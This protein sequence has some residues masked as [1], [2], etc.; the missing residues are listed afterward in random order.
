MV[1]S[2]NVQITVTDALCLFSTSRNVTQRVVSILHLSGRLGLVQFG[3][4]REWFLGLGLGL[5]LGHSRVL[6]RCENGLDPEDY[7]IGPPPKVHL[8]VSIPC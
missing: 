5:G 7:R 8:S 4:S 3:T 2:T 6:V 1:Q